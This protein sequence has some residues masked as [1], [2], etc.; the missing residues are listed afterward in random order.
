[1]NEKTVNIRNPEMGAS[2]IAKVLLGRLDRRLVEPAGAF[3]R[4][5]GWVMLTLIGYITM[6]GSLDAR[7]KTNVL[8]WLIGYAL[9]LLILEWVR[10]RGTEYYDSNRFRS[11]RIGF[12]LVAVT[13]LGAVAPAERYIFVFAYT[14][15]IIAAIAYFT[16]K[17]WVQIFVAALVLV[18]LIIG[19]ILS[20]GAFLITAELISSIFILAALAIGF[21]VFR[22]RVYSSPSNLTEVARELHKTL[23][24]QQLMIEILDR[25]L[26]ITQAQRG[27]IIVVNPENKRYVGHALK[28]FTLVEHRSIED[29]ALKCRVIKNGEPFESD[30]MQAAFN[31]SIYRDFFAAQPRSLAARPIYNRTGQ[32]MG[33]INVAHDDAGTF[34]RISK[35]QLRE[36]AYLIG[37]AIENCFEHRRVQLSEA[38][39]RETGEK[40]VSADSEDQVIQILIQEARLL[41]PHSE[42]ITLHQF[43]PNN[44]ELLPLHSITPET[45]SQYFPWSGQKTRGLKPDMRL[46]YGLAGHALEQRET[47][48]VNNTQHHPW[49][50][51]L[52]EKEDINSLLVA[53]L[54]DPD[55]VDY[56]GTI[57]LESSKVSAFSLEDETRLTSLS[58]QASR[59]IARMR[60]F[61]SWR[62]QG[63]ALRQILEKIGAFNPDASEND[64]CGQIAEEGARLLGFKV[65]VIRK[66][67]KDGETLT[68]VAVTGVSSAKKKKLLGTHFPYSE[69]KPFLIDDV[70]AESSYLIKRTTPAWQ[71]FVDR[72]LYKP[73]SGRNRKSRW[74]VYDA[75]ITPLQDS[76]GML[77]GILT[78]DVPGTGTEPSKQVLEL[79]GVFANSASWVIELSRTHQRL[80][81]QKSRT[82]SF[83][84]TI[85]R[86]LA[87]CRDVPAISEVVVQAG[88]KLLSAE[89][90]SIYLVHG[91]Y[92]ELA[93][94]NYLNKAGYIKRRKPITDQPGSGLTGWVAARGEILCLNNGRYTKHPAWAGEQDHLEYL[95]SRSC[96]SVLLAP[97]KD[98]EGKVIGVLTLENKRAVGGLKDFDDEDVMRLQRLAAEFAMA[99][100]VIGLYDEM[101]EWERSGLADDIHDLINWYHSG[102]VLWI[103][104][105]GDWFNKGDYEK[106]RELLPD[107]LQ[108]SHTTV[109]ELKTLHTIFLNKSFEA[110]TLKQALEEVMTVWKTRAMPKHKGR[111]NIDLNCPL[112]LD[113]PV[114]LR[115]TLIRIASLAFS[116]AIQ[117]SGILDDPAV[118]IRVQVKKSGRRI[119]LSV[120]DNGRGMDLENLRPGFGLERMKQL[121]E[122]INNWGVAK[123]DLKIDS[124][125]GRGT[126]IVLTLLPIPGKGIESDRR[127]Q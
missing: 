92:I 34:D 1:M 35:H 3:V 31:K 67:D 72:Y 91:D 14:L 29:L 76:S 21:E 56:Y 33:V 115:N 47:I 85:S 126:Q 104:A 84:D 110:S 73:P 61:E 24:L 102:V 117:H 83:I 38:K 127:L 58:S 22:R 36:F 77:L 4:I 116:N 109:N 106:T 113:I 23:D 11:F 54:L 2:K 124:R 90:C 123:S 88:A 69:L 40:F 64:L 70:R 42:K 108:H 15:P 48:L 97:V 43:L 59:V 20:P 87:D 81:E 45:T 71:E 94:S 10:R 125:V 39:S 111:M 112:D 62:K 75:L 50:V 78:L 17:I 46:G 18:G 25:A 63:G 101:R 98:K 114:K 27:L 119:I 80:K 7:A 26:E 41:I 122:K 16:G 51:R 82:E 19:Q 60:D 105:L 107:L 13:I 79:I 74:D 8:F 99:L 86:E 65:A 28:N 118:L 68:T 52:D 37:N 103:E 55:G 121:N 12:N 89:G 57:S 32:V 5:S 96:R 9:Y 66:L 6:F 120:M 93:H 44:E 49:F 100:E 30:D 53:P 95:P